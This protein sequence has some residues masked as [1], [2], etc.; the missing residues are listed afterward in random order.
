MLHC[1]KN[2]DIV[3]N[4]VDEFATVHGDGAMTIT[5]VRIN[6]KDLEEQIL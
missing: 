6:L 3:N 4:T 5:T 2:G 1:F